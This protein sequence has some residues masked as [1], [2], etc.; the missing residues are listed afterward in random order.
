MLHR[1][2]LVVHDKNSRSNLFY[3]LEL[4]TLFYTNRLY[5]VVSP[6]QT[7]KMMFAVV[8]LYGICWTPI[9]IYQL[10]LDYLPKLFH[11][12]CSE[13]HFYAMITY[14]FFAHWLAMSNTFVNPIV[15]S[16]MSKNFRVSD[17]RLISVNVSL[18]LI[19][20]DDQSVVLYR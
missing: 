5:I 7:I 9:K 19:V 16:F 11:I 20:I 8:I 15:Y 4:F 13:T 18:W 14:Y 2:T 10:A 12:N 1:K 3:W 17:Y 6:E